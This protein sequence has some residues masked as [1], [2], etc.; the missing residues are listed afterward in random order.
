[1]DAQQGEGANAERNE[2]ALVVA[3]F[4]T[5]KKARDITSR[6]FLFTQLSLFVL[7]LLTVWLV[8]VRLQVA[9]RSCNLAAC[10]KR[11]AAARVVDDQ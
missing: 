11:D 4:A 5:N 2:L 7:R 9:A 3:Q 6:A 8:V 10:S 1:M